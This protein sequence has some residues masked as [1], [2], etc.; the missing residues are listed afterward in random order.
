MKF[1]PLR[2]QTRSECKFALC[3]ELQKKRRGNLTIAVYYFVLGPWHF[4]FFSKG[5]G[6]KK[7]FLFSFCFFYGSKS[8]LFLPLWEILGRSGTSLFSKLNLR[9]NL[10]SHNHFF[11]FFLATVN[12]SQKRKTASFSHKEVWTSPRKTGLFPLSSA[13]SN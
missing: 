7:Q 10:L 3:R 5:D 9:S 8:V 4:L 6:K 1:T 11:F 12:S 2:L 13:K